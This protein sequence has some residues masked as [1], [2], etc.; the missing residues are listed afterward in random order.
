MGFTLIELLVVIA[1]IG[2]LSSVVLASLSSARAKARDAQR[3]SDMHAVIEAFELYANDH[4]NNY[5]VATATGDAACGGA[6]YCLATII[7][8]SLVPAKYIAKA[9][10][11]PTYANTGTNYRYC[12]GGGNSYAV[13]RYSEKISN[14][15]IPQTPF[16]PYHSCGSAPNTW[17]TFP[18]CQ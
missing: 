17:D 6:G 3:A 15:C 12:S 16:I 2:I 4:N 5:P 8:A 13:I 11:D 9:P 18:S 1:I 10:A 7:N 14:W